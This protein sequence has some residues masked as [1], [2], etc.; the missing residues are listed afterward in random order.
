MR[1]TRT[2]TAL[3]ALFWVP[4][5]LAAAWIVTWPPHTV[6]GPAH[7]LGATAIA[8]YRGGFY[9]Q[10]YELDWFPTPNVAG[11]ALL[12]ALVKVGS[13]RFAETVVLLLAALGTP[14]AL[15]WA[16]RVVRPESD[17]L[18]L[19]A[20][21]LC[22]GYLYFYGFWN[23]CLG[24]AL[25]LVCAGL[26]LRAAP[27]WRTRPTV[28]LTGLLTLTWLTHLVPFVAAAIFLGAVV[29]T[30]P[31][32]LRAWRAPGL[33]LLPGAALS[34]AYLLRTDAGEGPTWTGPVGRL[35]GLVSLHTTVTTFSR[36]EDAIA[37]AVA[38]VL[39]GLGVRAVRAGARWDTAAV[40]ALATTA[41]ML[42]TP[43]RFGIDFGLIDERL[44]VFPVLF[45]LL[46]LAAAPPPPRVALAAATALAVATGTLAAVRVPE[47]RRYDRLA[48]EYAR[49][50]EFTEPGTVLL[51][52]RFHAYAPDAGRNSGWDPVRHLSSALAA[53]TGSIDVGHYEA[54]LDYFPARFREGN[55]RGGI[56]RDLRGLGQVPPV[57]DLVTF[58]PR[59][60][61][62][63]PGASREARAIR[64]S[65]VVRY[66]FV[67]GAL[68]VRAQDRRALADVRAR[69]RCDYELVGTTAPRGLVEVWRL[70]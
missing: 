27:E 45:G 24:V 69:L 4:L 47:L 29:V 36:W 52:L 7:L 12:A 44:A 23:Y 41:L 51:A 14:L 34:G 21:P 19:A 40:A 3:A 48:D 22:F 43:T 58:N 35:A 53:R 65:N 50:A 55:A 33:A 63:P 15:R 2:E 8:E 54:V 37:G 64:T 67:V 10:Y 9:G 11:T 25:A 32:A 6:D 39:V 28:A 17:W 18:A 59:C 57:V 26:A 1:L 70:R 56:D 68:D 62:P 60:Q 13:L 31:R 38:V 30:G 5:A 16:I 46:W 42:V 61:D 20:L 49:A 66:V